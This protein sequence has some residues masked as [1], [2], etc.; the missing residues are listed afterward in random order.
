MEEHTQIGRKSRACTRASIMAPPELSQVQCVDGYTQGGAAHT[1]SME[2]AQQWWSSSAL[3]EHT[4][5]TRTPHCQ[6][7]MPQGHGYRT[8]AVIWML[9]AKRGRT[10]CNHNSTMEK[11]SRKCSMRVRQGCASV[12]CMMRVKHCEWHMNGFAMKPKHIS[13]GKSKL[14]Q[15][16]NKAG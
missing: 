3:Q 6:K 4:N 9:Q 5:V 14:L 2:N 8:S 13:L 16:L 1:A 10:K 15:E 12:T 7:C 11:T